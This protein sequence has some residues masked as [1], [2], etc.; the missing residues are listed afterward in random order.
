MAAPPAPSRLRALAA[1][2]LPYAPALAASGALGALCIRAILAQAGSPALPLDDA[3][4]HMQYARRLAE[5]GFFSFVAGDGYSSG[6]TSLLW[7][8]LLA[9]FHALGLRDL[10]LVYA[11]WALGLVFHAALA[12][13]TARLARPLA[14]PAAAAGAGAMCAGFAAFAWF[15]WSGMETVAFAWILTRT[16]RLAAALCEPAPPEPATDSAAPALPPGAP[17]LPPTAP[18]ARSLA[19]CGFVAPLLRPEGALASLLAAI[20]L[21]LSASRAV[22]PAPLAAPPLSAPSPSRSDALWHSARS[23]RSAGRLLALAPLLGPLVVPAL[24]Q[25]L[26]GHPTSSTTS[27][28]WLIGNPNYDG[29]TLRAALLDNVRL[30]VTDVID[31]GQWTAVFLPEGSAA[32]IALGAVALAVAAHRRGRPAHAAIVGALALGALL[33]CTYLSFL[34]N[35]VRYVWPF[36]PAWIVMAACLARELGD[37]AQRLRPSL[38][39]VTPLLAG[40]FAGALA[41][42][43]PWA[44]GD[45]ANSARAIDRQ[46]VWLGRWAARHLPEDARIGVNDTGALAYFSGRRTFDVVGLTTEGE[47]RYWV[48]GAGS[49]FEHYE[50]LPPERR[51]THFIVYPHWMA[52]PPVLGRALVDATV[53]DQAILGG[54]TMIAYEARWDLLGSGALPVRSVPGERILDELDVSDLESE[55]AHAYAL[56]PLADQRNLAIALAAP[57]SSAPG[58]LDPTRTE[59]ADGGRY[60]RTADRFVVHLAAPPAEARLVLRVA[61]D[62]GAELAVSVAGEAIGTVDVPR[63]R[64]VERAL[65]LPAARLSTPAPIAITLRRG[66]GFHAFHYWITGR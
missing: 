17:A 15:A 23:A 4:I 19:L 37:A 10:S 30:L 42:R 38:H 24:N 53:E 48:A 45:L 33:P 8:V 6:A 5:G 61:S 40:A 58:E 56:D 47:A 43:L 49:R 59:L 54:T 64:W 39:Y 62:D 46:Q 3:F 65:P 28:K 25:L 52:C 29:P 55:A 22:P 27:V 35:R 44:I 14:G 51:P 21:A 13:E 60:H 26:A 20:A 16:A 9:P 1:R 2:A 18:I 57:E 11:V 31:G 41:A 66:A 36:A 50:K 12:V 63:G 32:V 34:W 7:P